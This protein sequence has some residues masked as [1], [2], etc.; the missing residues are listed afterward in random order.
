MKV[1]DKGSKGQVLVLVALMMVMLL[2]I[3]ALAIDLGRAY[4]VKTKL[5][6]AVDAAS[7]EAAGA[8]AEG[9]GESGMRAKALQVAANYFSANYNSEGFM[10]ATPSAPT[11]TANRDGKSGAWT[12]NVA[13]TATM[14][15]MFAGAFANLLDG[16]ETERLN[17]LNIGAASETTRAT[18]DMALVLDTTNSLGDDFP[19]VKAGAQNF[20]THFSTLDDRVSVV[21]FSA[22]AFPVV[23]F[24][25]NNTPNP[26]SNSVDCGRGFDRVAVHQTIGYLNKSMGTNSEGGLKKGLAQLNALKAEARSGKRAIVFFSDGS[27][28][29][30]NGKF[31]TNAGTIEANLY[32]GPRVNELADQLFR[33]AEHQNNGTSFATALLAPWPEND[34]KGVFSTKNNRRPFSGVTTD[35]LMYKCDA[36][37]AARNMA[38]NV[39]DEVRNQGITVFTLGFGLQLNESEVADAGCKTKEEKGSTILKRFANTADSDTYNN[40]QPTGIFC[41]APT[42]NE[43]EGCF[44]QIA[45]GILR[46]TK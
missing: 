39:A 6:A 16:K 36:N 37:K 8:L 7:Y 2:G 38:E 5:N 27:P 24:C 12:V 20:L 3:A 1:L 32:S 26:D 35:E 40:R 9:S 13:A 11:V 14:P 10:G 29:T 17:Y 15:T 28:N 41:Y 42:I 45:Y 43:L 31:P 23:S 34:A 21:A 46:I 4:G 19:N 25:G 18:I 33:P 44:D 30:F 22:G